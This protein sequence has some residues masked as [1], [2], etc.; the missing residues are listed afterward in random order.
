MEFD[1][2]GAEWV[3]VAYDSGDKNMI[4]VCESGESPHTH[5]G[6]LISGAPKELIIRE[7]KIC[8]K[9]TDPVELEERRRAAIPEIFQGGYF[10]P[11]IF[12]IRQAGKKSNH[13]LNYGMQFRRFALENEMDETESK[14]IVTYYSEKA[15]PGLP[16]WWEG[17]KRQLR[18]NRTLVNCFGRKRRFLEQWGPDL[19]MEA[20]AFIP[21][22]TI[23]D[24]FNIGMPEI[25]ADQTRSFR[26]LKIKN[27]VHDSGVFQ[28]DV[29]LSRDGY[30]RAARC[31][32]RIAFKYLNPLMEYGGREFR[33]RTDLKIGRHWGEDM[34][35]VDLANGNEVKIAENLEAAITKIRKEEEA[36]WQ[37]AA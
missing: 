17:K 8:G 10:V 30:A 34:I 4:Q 5:T 12:T 25:Y 35:G 37:K 31:I 3:I 9:V 32:R 23:V 33:I 27:Q 2:A 14:K 13:G 6:H 22:S 20:F 18:D 21:Q 26:T 19:F 16:G 1:K 36:N 15:Y 11:R 7:D 28:L 29:D 24:I